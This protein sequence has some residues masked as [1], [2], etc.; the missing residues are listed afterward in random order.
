MSFQKGN[1]LWKL[2]KN[3][4][5]PRK[6]KT[7]DDVRQAALDYFEWAS[8]NPLIEQKL[9]SYQGE[10]YLEPVPKMRPFT[11]QGLAVYMGVSINTWLSY[12]KDSDFLDVC[13]WVNDVIFTQ[14]YE[15]A[16]TGLLQHQIVARYLGLAEKQEVTTDTKELEGNKAILEEAKRRFTGAEIDRMSVFLLIDKLDPKTAFDKVLSERDVIDGELG[17]AIS[18]KDKT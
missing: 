3:P 18:G 16:S 10:S 11:K 14:Q 7:A 2:R 1:S 5:R 15:G 12:E 9:V 8:D 6:Y 4:G 17:D 13:A